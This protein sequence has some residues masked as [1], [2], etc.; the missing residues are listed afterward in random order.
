MENTIEQEF[1]QIFENRQPA[2]LYDPISYTLLQS[3]K[4]LRPKLVHM[5]V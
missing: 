5:A 2:N 3:G 1:Q 4:R